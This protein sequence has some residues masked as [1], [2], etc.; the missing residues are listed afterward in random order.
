[1]RNSNINPP[2][3][4]MVP[5]FKLIPRRKK[6]NKLYSARSGSGPPGK[7]KLTKKIKMINNSSQWTKLFTSDT[8]LVTIAKQN[9]DFST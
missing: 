2:L 5:K 4:P 9:L 6:R 8:L 1:M 3:M 7:S